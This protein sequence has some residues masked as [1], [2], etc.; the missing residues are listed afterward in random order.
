MFL[1]G[2]GWIEGTIMAAFGLE[3]LNLIKET[4]TF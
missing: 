1:N 2:P 4:W 3:E